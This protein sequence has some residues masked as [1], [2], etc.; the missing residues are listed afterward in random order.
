MRGYVGLIGDRRGSLSLRYSE[1]TRDVLYRASFYFAF[2]SAVAILLSIAIS[3]TL[4]GLSLAALLGSR[5]KLRMPPVWLPLALFCGGTLI[6]LAFSPEPMHGLPQVK[7]MFV[8]AMLLVIFTTVRDVMT[9]RRLVLFWAV[10]GA[11]A[12]CLGVVQFAV[13]VFQAAA[14]HRNFYEFYTPNRITGTM[15][16]WMTFA[17]QEM[18]VLLM[19]MAFLFFAPRDRK[20]GWVWILCAFLLATAELLNET[21]TAWLGIAAAG[22]WLI[23]GWKRWMLIC[24]PA[25]VLVLA[26]IPGPVH[27]RFVSIVQPKETD[28]NS[29]RWLAVWTG[30]RMIEAHP[31]LGIGPDETKYHFRDWMPPDR[32]NPLP[33]GYYQH[34]ENVYLQYAAER[35]IP[36]LLTMLWLLGM[37][38][39]DFFRRLRALPAGRSNERFLLQGGIA[40]VIAIMVSGLGEVNLGDSEVLTVFLVV[41][42]CGYVAVGKVDSRIAHR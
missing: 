26:L 4:L 17:G 24:V 35:G 18:I 40:T 16:H 5:A 39:W 22:I 28:S 3:Q 30:V 34:L 6:S 33:S 14:Q 21:R 25:A 9:A 1:H 29:Y 23:W 31:V 27:Q 32:P 36:T 13:K 10:V 20:R 2:A 41:V 42:A 15:S 37:T 11:A 7:K 12:S 38:V 8:Y 19:L